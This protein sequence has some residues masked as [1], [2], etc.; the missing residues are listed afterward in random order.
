MFLHTCFGELV[1]H[2]PVLRPVD[3]R[4]EF[5]DPIVSARKKAEKMDI[6]GERKKGRDV[7]ASTPSSV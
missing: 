7:S 5:M 1:Q 4:N 6:N 3:N 2:L